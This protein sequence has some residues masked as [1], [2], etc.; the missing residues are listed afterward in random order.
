VAEDAVSAQLSTALGLGIRELA[1]ALVLVMSGAATVALVLVMSGA[2]TVALASVEAARGRWRF[3]RRRPGTV[4]AGSW[5]PAEAGVRV[6]LEGGPTRFRAGRLTIV[7]EDGGALA[8]GRPGR[9]RAS[10]G[11]LVVGPGC[12]LRVAA[13]EVGHPEESPVEARGLWLCAGSPGRR[14]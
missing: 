5:A 13:A 3:L 4:S 1:H 8:I 10:A 12:T 6:L 7:V 2:A 14:R 9:H 11:T